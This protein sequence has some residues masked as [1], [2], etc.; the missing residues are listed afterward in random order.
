[1]VKKPQNNKVPKVNMSVSEDMTPEQEHEFLQGCPTRFEVSS[2]VAQYSQN[3]LM[4]YILAFMER[5]LKQTVTM[6]SILQALIVNSGLA[7]EEQ[8]QELF[9]SFQEKEEKEQNKE[10]IDN[11][12]IEVV[13]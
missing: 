1:M 13:K 2:F 3:E 8:I 5:Q 12:E 11:S 6:V 4:P 9:K 7:T 10:P